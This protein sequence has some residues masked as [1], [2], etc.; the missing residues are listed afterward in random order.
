[1]FAVFSPP[2]ASLQASP[3]TDLINGGF[4]TKAE[5]VSHCR[6]NTQDY[7][8]ILAYFG[9]SCDN[10]SDATLTTIAP[11]DNNDKLYSMGRL[12]YGVPGEVPIRIPGVT[13]VYA[14]HF[15]SLNHQ[16]SYKALRL[17]NSVG[18]TYFILYDCGNLVTTGVPTPPPPVDACPNKAGQQDSKDEC[19]VCPN[20]P[21]IQLERKD[22]DVCPNKT[23]TQTTTTQC[24]VCPDK[25]G[26]Q[27]T[28]E[29]C[30]VCPNIPDIQTTKDQCDVCPDKDGV[31][32][33][34]SECKPCENAQTKNDL[35][36]CLIY[37]K[38]ASNLSQ[39]LPD[40]NGST[41]KPGDTVEYTLTTKN[42]GEITIKGYQVSDG[43]ADVLDYADV[44]DLHGGTMDQYQQIT[45][46]KVDIKAGQSITNKVTIKVKSV[47]PQTP[48][49]SSDPQ[50]F[51]MVM[52]NVYGNTVEIKL[53]ETPQ[54]QIEIATTSLPNT[55][56]GTSLLIGFSLT[57]VV[58][59]FFMRSRLLTKELDIVRADF[60][61][62]GGY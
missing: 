16:P 45:W 52:T 28:L 30:D 41:A 54:K 49:S 58:A 34:E 38:K 10:V 9:I 23:G 62:A 56:P 5:A 36:A 44:V 13:T 51:N 25:T 33:D 6:N 43:F 48:A 47:I 22:C 7:K 20:R 42:S 32:S 61:A 59:Y 19:D 46:P 24:D 53:P 60:G 39:N 17:V 35:T 37:S 14:R 8:K 1:M 57:L 15:W 26:T 21:G 31:Q 18:K 27:T 4:S 50:H 2:Q 11:H 3:S 12:S 55:G 40:A 29:Q